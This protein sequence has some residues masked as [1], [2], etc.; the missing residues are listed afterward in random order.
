[1][2]EVK[3]A[4]FILFLIMIMLASSGLSSAT[5]RN[6]YVGDLI[7]LKITTEVLT[8]DEVREKFRDF[9][10]VDLKTVSDG[11][12]ITIR[13][14]E[15]GEKIINIGSSEIV[16]TVKST[17]EEIE[18]NEPFEGDMS[19]ESPGFSIYYNLLF[20][21]LVFASFVTGGILLAN[22]IKRRRDSQKSPYQRF[23]E[24]IKKLSFE[25]GKYLVMITRCLKEYLEQK[26]TLDIKGKTSSEIIR[27]ISTVQDLQPVSGKVHNWLGE[28]DHYKFSGVFSTPE[29][30]Q[31]LLSELKEIV[32]EI[33]R[34]NEGKAC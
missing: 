17:L 23:T 5:E 15:A 25:D 2:K 21:I 27:E 12:L 8:E 22:Y 33:E 34:T 9:E 16:I 13:T 1:M 11:F 19:P 3:K 4:V 18:R 28:M 7:E 24:R 10:I 29:K 20:Y 26:F 6:I 32:S 14:F 30:K 31:E